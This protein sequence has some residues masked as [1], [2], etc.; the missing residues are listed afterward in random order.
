V[1]YDVGVHC[2]TCGESLNHAFTSLPYGFN[3]LFEHLGLGKVESWKSK[4]GIEMLPRLAS[5]LRQLEDDEEF[6]RNKFESRDDAWSRI[7][8]A[9]RFLRAMRD[10]FCRDPFATLS[11]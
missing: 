10:A 8:F 2:H 9:P 11:I 5:A 7:D 6:L 4:T 1:S 3:A